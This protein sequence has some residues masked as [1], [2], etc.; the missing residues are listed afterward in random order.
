MTKKRLNWLKRGGNCQT[1]S[2]AG[3]NIKW[4]WLVHF[5]SSLSAQSAK[6]FICTKS[7]VSS[8]SRKSVNRTF[9]EALCTQKLRFSALLALFLESTETLLFV[10]IDVLAVWA[11]PKLPL[12]T[13]N[14]ST[15]ARIV[16]YYAIM[17]LLC[18]PNLLLR[19]PFLEREECL[20]FPGKSCPHKLRRDSKSPRHTKNWLRGHLPPQILPIFI[21]FFFPVL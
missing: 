8:D 11:V 21:V 4:N 2:K 15:I 16:N 5:L 10:Q 17:F 6:T 1:L 9:S 3:G 14:T 20:E 18:P 19:G 13:K 12:R 7:W